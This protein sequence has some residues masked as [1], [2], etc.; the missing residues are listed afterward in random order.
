MGR[1]II[2]ILLLRNV[3]YMATLS[4]SSKIFTDYCKGRKCLSTMKCL[5][6]L[7]FPNRG[8]ISRRMSTSS[9][10]M[11][12]RFERWIV[13]IV[14]QGYSHLSRLFAII[15]WHHGTAIWMN[16]CLFEF[17]ILTHLKSKNSIA[18]KNSR[19]IIQVTKWKMMPHCG[20]GFMACGTYEL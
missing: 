1:S 12:G 20:I 11:V 5:S 7:L 13:W 16:H 2:L 14:W 4:P 18:K 3:F 10:W 15:S 6:L 17:G 8:Y 9:T 19:R